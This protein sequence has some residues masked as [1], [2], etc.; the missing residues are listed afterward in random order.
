MEGLTYLSQAQA[1]A[2]D[3]ELMG[4]DFGFTLEQLMELA[5]LSVACAI[6]EVYKPASSSRVLVLCGPGNNGGDGLVAARHLAHFGYTPHVCYPKPTDKPIYHGLVKQLKSQEV[7]FVEAG[8]LPSDLASEFDLVVDA[9]FGFSFRGAPRPPF[10]TILQQLASL[11][12]A[13]RPQIVSVDVPSGWHVEEG[14]TTG[15]GL[16]PHMLVSLTAP[17]QCAR[18]FRGDHHFVGGRFVPAA[19][20]RKLQITLPRYQG[21]APMVQLSGSGRREETPGLPSRIDIAALRENY[22]AGELLEEQAD[23]DPFKQFGRWFEDATS[24]NIKEPNG[25]TLATVSDTGAPSARVVLLKGFDSRGFVWYTN[26]E[27]RKGR[28][29]AVFP[30][31][32]LVFWWEPLQRQVRVEGSVERVTSKESDQYFYSRPRG[33]QLGAAS[34]P[35]SRVIEDRHVLDEHYKQLDEKYANSPLPR[36]DTWGGFRLKPTCIEFW[37]GRPSRLHDRLRYR[38]DNEQAGWTI[39]RLAP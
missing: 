4:D 39:E 20:A 37:Q 1:A 9:I 11:E 12:G 32:A 38:W 29:L 16:Q 17:K 5:G 24:S 21:S 36:P 6:F 19:V 25:M 22:T 8:D 3:E 13:A 2:V 7:P 31:A 18:G 10:D 34:S 26:Y 28:E 33:S 27:S 35:Q 30:R 15:V 14:D 23:P